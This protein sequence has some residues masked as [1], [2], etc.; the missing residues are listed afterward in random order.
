M[1]EIQQKHVKAGVKNQMPLLEVD[2]HNSYLQHLTI[3][4]H[5]LS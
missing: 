5:I 1:C 4:A 3:V 2:I